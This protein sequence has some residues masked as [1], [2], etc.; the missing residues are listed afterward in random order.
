MSTSER[1]SCE[2]STIASGYH[3][4][5]TPNITIYN[6]HGQMGHYAG[7]SL[8]LD[9]ST[10]VLSVLGA[11]VP[12]S[13]QRPVSGGPSVPNR[14][15]LDHVPSTT[16]PPPLPA[17]PVESVYSQSADSGAGAASESLHLEVVTR[18]RGFHFRF[19]SC[20]EAECHKWEAL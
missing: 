19:D 11:T 14:R 2:R 16:A 12:M 15:D 1:S 13:G 7:A 9:I 17:P 8:R 6:A 4:V 20:R 10:A 18:A 3:C 5:Q